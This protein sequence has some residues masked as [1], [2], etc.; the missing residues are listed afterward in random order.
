MQFSG[1]NTFIGATTVTGGLLTVSGA[2]AKLGS[3]NVIVQASVGGSELQIQSSVQNAIANTATLS[4]LN[5]AMGSSGLAALVAGGATVDLGTGINETVQMLVL[6]GAVQGPGT[7]G[8][9][10]SSA[11]FKNDTF[12]SGTGIIT[13]SV[14]EPTVASLLLV[15]VASLVVRRRSR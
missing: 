11:I 7:Y 12:F 15:G 10:S 5:G 8:S 2:A 4:I 13:V 14:P 1:A 6:N 9:S 3:G